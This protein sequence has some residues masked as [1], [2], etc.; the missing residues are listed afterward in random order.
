MYFMCVC[1]YINWITITKV[2]ACVCTCASCCCCLLSPHVGKFQKVK[3]RPARSKS[4]CVSV[5]VYVW[6]FRMWNGVLP[7]WAQSIVTEPRTASNCSLFVV[8]FPG[9]VFHISMRFFF[10]IPW[11]S[12]SSLGQLWHSS[13]SRIFSLHAWDLGIWSFSWFLHRLVQNHRY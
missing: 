7:R 3:Q 5:C 13:A 8:I 10:I 4:V 2:C 12:S 1:T 6:G 9:M 11:G